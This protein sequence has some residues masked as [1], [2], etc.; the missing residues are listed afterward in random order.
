MRRLV[1]FVAT[2]SAVAVVVGASS[3]REATWPE[4]SPPTFTAGV[5]LVSIAAVVRDRRGRVVRGLS[6]DD[7][8][9]LDHGRVRDV[10][11]VRPEADASISLA[12]LID[13]SGSMGLA[14][15]LDVARDTATRL[16][17]VLDER[18]DEVALISFDTELRVLR[19]FEDGASSF[20]ESLAGI[21]AFGSTSL[22]DA[23]ATTARLA[24]ARSDRRAAVIVLTDGLDTTSRLSAAE[25]SGLA[26]EIAVPV[27]VVVSASPLDDP[28][29]EIG[30]G[31][32]AGPRSGD[33]D[34]LARWTGGGLVVLSRGRSPDPAVRGLVA[35]LRHRYL[36]AFEASGPIGWHPIEV[37]AR[38]RRL[39]VRA[40]GG[41]MVSA[42]PGAEQ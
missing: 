39:T 35:E 9:V 30:L 16:F 13:G 6:R 23:V 33:L 29:A 8:S 11:E 4:Q 15:K 36:I 27:Y 21:E 41:Y 34:D 40:R 38:D 5:D 10:L 25:V 18:R 3:A 19:G 24:G 2:V 12:I 26:N 32:E 17:A 7:F 31:D 28:S 20:A 42:T 1:R 22:Y 14:S 37:R